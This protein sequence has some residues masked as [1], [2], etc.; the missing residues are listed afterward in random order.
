MEI[1]E[2][3]GVGSAGDVLRA[4]DAPEHVFQHLSR[5]LGLLTLIVW[6]RPLGV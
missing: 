5:S 3:R 1:H 4:S 6:W 2:A